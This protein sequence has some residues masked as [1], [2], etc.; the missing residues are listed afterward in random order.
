MQNVNISS[1]KELIQISN[2][3]TGLKQDSILWFHLQI[4]KLGRRI[5]PF[6]W[7]VN[8]CNDYRKDK[9]LLQMTLLMTDLQLIGNILQF[10]PFPFLP[11]KKKENINSKENFR[12][13]D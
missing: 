9:V 3:D 2:A 12:N 5:I 11:C 13:R 7:V 4:S 6:P 1:N 10:S 8:V